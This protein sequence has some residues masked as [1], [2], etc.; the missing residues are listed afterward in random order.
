MVFEPKRKQFWQVGLEIDQRLE[1]VAVKVVLQDVV[2]RLAFVL[3]KTPPKLHDQYVE[4]VG[5]Y[6]AKLKIVST[7]F[8]QF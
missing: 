6:L 5:L 8:K 1:T 3:T 2:E 7:I 4:S